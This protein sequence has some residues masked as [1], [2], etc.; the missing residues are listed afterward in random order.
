MTRDTQL[1]LTTGGVIFALAV[2]VG[3]PIFFALQP[4]SP[5]QPSTAEQALAICKANGGLPSV[6]S[7]QVATDVD[8]DGRTHPV[9]K[10]ELTCEAKK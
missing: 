6:A 2:C 10:E 7:K 5:P 1:I 3:L 9:I 4:K 8:I